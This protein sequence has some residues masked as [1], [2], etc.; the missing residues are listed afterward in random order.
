MN[1]KTRIAAVA[2]SVTLVALAGACNPDLNVTNPNAP[3]VARA[4]ASPGDVRNLI[5]NSYFTFYVAQNIGTG[6]EPLPGPALEGMADVFTMGYGNFGMR[7][8]HLEPRTA[9]RNST[10]LGDGLVASVPYDNIYGGLGAANDGLN[11][12][13][14][15]VKVATAAN[16]TDE[17]PQFKA[18]ALYTQGGSLAWESV[19]F[20]RGFIVLEDTPQG[21]ATLKPFAE[22]NAAGIA[23]LEKA[24]AEAAGKTW[25]LPPEFFPGL[26]PLTADKFRR[27]ASTM[28]ARYLVYNARTAAQNATTNWTKVLAFANAGISTGS[29]P[30]DLA[31]EGDGGN[32]W[33]DHN[34]YYSQSQSWIRID[35]RVVQLF[36]PATQ[37]VVYTSVTPP[38]RA[39]SKDKRIGTTAV[40]GTD[41]TFISRIPYAP[42]RGVWNFSQWSHI[43]YFIHSFESDNEL[44]GTM[45]YV[46]AAENDLIIAEALI[47]TNGSRTQAA[48]LINKTRVDR[49]GLAPVTGAETN[50]VLL[51]ALFY[52]REI[53]LM[54]TGAARGYFD[55][56][57]ID[58]DLTYEG[59]PIGNTWAFRG[60]NSLQKGTARHMPLP[61]KELETLGMPVYT[62]GGD[63]PNPVFP[64]M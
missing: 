50:Q 26:A 40:P 53:E 22:V 3:D 64:D 1:L 29:A 58:L 52:E 20:D 16:A 18:L 41:F 39:Q 11:A 23:S 45:P 30:F 46:L 56:R 48:A 44:T 33:Y 13:K 60:G 59:L 63:A 54:A 4:V 9:F 36:D 47:R 31:I 57:R 7:L 38:P 27:M 5:G 25:T 15:G 19:L 2:G 17:T 14:R 51:G 24:I 28:A 8:N 32:K 34:K 42:A 43:R 62:Y 6:N 49:G 21:T 10:A 37:P 61:A 35:Q 55:R 12:I